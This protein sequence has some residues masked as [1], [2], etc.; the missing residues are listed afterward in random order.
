MVL[1]QDIPVKLNV[2]D[3]IE[4]IQH[5]MDQQKQVDIILLD[6][7]KTFD[8]VLYQRLLTKLAHYGI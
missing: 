2:I 6:F 8:T 7:S 3:F 5:T 4:N 1:D